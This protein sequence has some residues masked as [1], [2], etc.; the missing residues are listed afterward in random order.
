MA[1]RTPLSGKEYGAMQTV[2]GIVSTFSAALERLHKRALQA[3]DGTWRDLRLIETKAASVTDRLLATVPYNKLQQIKTDLGN[4]R[5]YIKVEPSW[6]PGTVQPYC[7]VPTKALNELLSHLL[8][9]ECLFC[10]KTATEARHCPYRQLIEQ[11]LPHEV[12]GNDAQDC[13]YAGIAL[14]LD[15][16]DE[17]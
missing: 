10:S 17:K 4:T 7:C 12:P 6:A 11:T 2:F 9:S 1:Q 15:S 5:C 8:G 13:K 3:G 16:V 14:G